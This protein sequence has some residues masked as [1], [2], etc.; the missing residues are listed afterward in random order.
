M[1]NMLNAISFLEVQDGVLAGAGEI[2]DRMSELKE[3]LSRCH[4]KRN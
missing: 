1:Q 4:E 2:V 3:P